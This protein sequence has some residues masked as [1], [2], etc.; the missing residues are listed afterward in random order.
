MQ[1]CDA[2]T[3]VRRAKGHPNFHCHHLE[4]PEFLELELKDC[5]V[6]HLEFQATCSQAW[7]SRAFQAGGFPESVPVF[8][9]LLGGLA[10][11][12]RVVSNGPLGQA[13]SS[14]FIGFCTIELGSPNREL[15]IDPALNEGCR[16]WLF[17]H[18]AIRKD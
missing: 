15:Q 3:S 18:K 7:S 16:G 14:P 2:T 13:E 9:L 5:L 17:I 1:H 8:L 10:R 4:F 6:F 11:R 12:S